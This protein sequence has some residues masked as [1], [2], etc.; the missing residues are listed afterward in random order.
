MTR[1]KT[2]R[3]SLEA[4]EDRCL[5]AEVAITAPASGARVWNAIPV[6]ADASAPTGIASV[7]FQLDGVNM[8]SALTRAPYTYTWPTAQVGNGAHTLTATAV[9][10]AGN[11]VTSSP[12]S[13]TV[14]NNDTSGLLLINHHIQT[15]SGGNIAPW[16]S[17]D[18][19]TA[20]D[21]DMDLAWQFWKNIPNDSLGYG[22]PGYYSLRQLY[23][24]YPDDSIGIGGDQFAMAIDSWIHYY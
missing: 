2:V 20:Y 7:Q 21:R 4:L 11:T 17:S 23:L 12:V 19:G 8:G 13:V 22:M 6:S 10:N 24:Q 1:S 9:D 3:L 15:D 16:F 14:N 18:P 5:L